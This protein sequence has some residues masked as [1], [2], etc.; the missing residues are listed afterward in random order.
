MGSKLETFEM[1]AH[2]RVHARHSL[3]DQLGRLWQQITTR[4]RLQLVMLLF[5]TLG[6]SAVE[7][8]SVGAVVPFL[9]ALV[10]PE[11]LFGHPKLVSLFP[12]FGIRDVG[13]L[14]VFLTLF[15]VVA[16]L[17]SGGMRVA[18][19]WV[20]VRLAFA[21]GSDL[22]C[23]IYRRT[24]YQPYSV[25]VSRNSSH[26]ITAIITKVGAVITGVISPVMLL[27]SSA[28]IVIAIIGILFI[29]NVQ[30]TLFVMA[31]FGVIYLGVIRLTRKA[32]LE[33][34]RHISN[35]STHVVKALQ[36][37]LG[38]IRDIL[39]DGSQET[40]CA[41]YRNADIPLKRAQGSN[42]FIAMSPRFAIEAIGM[43]I[44]A[45][46]AL[47][48]SRQPGGMDASIPILG[49]LAIG[50]QRLLPVLQQ[51]YA[52][53]SSVVGNQSILEEALVL[54]EQ[55]APSENGGNT[56]SAIRFDKQ[57]RF[58]EIAFR[59]G[60]DQPMI[61]EGVEIVIEKGDRV[62]IIGKTGSGKT[63]FVDLLM[64]LLDPVTGYVEVDGV[65]LTKGNQGAWQRHI[66]HVPQNIFLTDNSIA[67]NIAFGIP[68]AEIDLDR[69][70]RAA[71]QAQ[72]AAD[73]ESWPDGYETRV[74]ERGIRLSGGQRQ[75]IGIARALYKQADVIVFDEATSALDGETER[76][77]MK[78]IESLSGELTVFVIAHRR[79]TLKNCSKIIE[80]VKGGAPHIR[81]YDEISETPH[82]R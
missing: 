26:V 75:R 81:T 3:P 82:W 56:A 2:G 24:L 14:Q 13:E 73:V 28:V 18:M 33:N 35:N 12:L 44:I 71:L 59:Y 68:R 27:I 30:V 77:V 15:F 31:G 21:T 72:I 42:Q 64:G 19:T 34:G 69:V 61:L 38:G 41:I 52:A 1:T 76:A 20:S 16:A 11:K 65:R 63:T 46:V 6:A 70:K 9:S 23:T 54:L 39:L 47:L 80:V 79:S 78:A 48:L 66:A 45:G 43:S 40:Y 5:L 57:I 67:E 53:W 22:S 62:G 17:L 74:G 49:A 7:V 36:E 32:K 10:A 37:G 51:A 25:H 60:P 29:V 50:A 55:P 8:I 4:R 58:C